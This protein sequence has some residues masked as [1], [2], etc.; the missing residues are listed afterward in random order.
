MP[1]LKDRTLLLTIARV[2]EKVRVNVIA[3]KAKEREDQAP[4]TPLNYT[5]SPE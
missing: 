1:L 2:G 5:S 4:T 3:A